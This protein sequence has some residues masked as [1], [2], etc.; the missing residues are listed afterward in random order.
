[1]VPTAT[2]VAAASVPHVI[3]WP[4]VPLARPP[5]GNPVALVKTP[6]AGVPRA[7]VTRVGLVANTASPVPVSSVKAE[8]RLALD[9]VP[10]N[11]AIPEAKLVIPRRSRPLLVVLQ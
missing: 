8:R 7:G 11:V 6:D 3:S 1:M 9:G 2:V 10:K 5:T 4:S